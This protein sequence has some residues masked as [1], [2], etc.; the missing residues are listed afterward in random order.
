[1]SRMPSLPLSLKKAVCGGVLMLVLCLVP[2]VAAAAPNTSSVAPLTDEQAAKL[3][4][5]CTKSTFLGLVPWYKYI[6]KEL[7]RGE[8]AIKSSNFDKKGGSSYRCDVKCFNLLDQ[9]STANECGQKKSDVP[10]VLLAIVDNLLRITGVVAVG[11]VFYG[12]IRYTASQ[13]NP[14]QTAKAQSTIVNAVV[15]V[16]LAS[17]AIGFVSYLGNT[18]GQ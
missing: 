8:T 2:A 17:V 3:V 12:A 16:V 11:F 5:E 9:G 10:L 18:L 14:E 13:G 15:G 1:M 7:N 4:E 6:G